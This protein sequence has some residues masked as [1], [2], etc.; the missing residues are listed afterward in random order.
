MLDDG[1]AVRITVAKYYTPSGRL[2]QREFENGIDEYYNNLL[3]DNREASDSLLAKKPVFKTKKGRNVYGGGGITPDVYSTQNIDF[4]PST[5]KILT[6]PNR[7]IFKYAKN[8]ENKFKK[9]RNKSFNNFYSYI[10]KNKKTIVNQNEFIDWCNKNNNELN[11][12]KDEIDKDWV[13]IENRILAELANSIWSK[14]DYYHVLLNEDQQFL[15]ALE[16]MEKAKLL[17]D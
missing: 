4:S 15:K 13:Y 10:Q 5:Q 11:L 12:I 16:S 17:V 7:L 14:N 3:T 2:I 1:S 9:F 8:I 6:D